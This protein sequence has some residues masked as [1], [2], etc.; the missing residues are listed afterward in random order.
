[1]QKSTVIKKADVKK[2][3]YLIDATGVSLG[4][5]SVA[6]SKL[7]IGKN[8]LTYASNLDSGDNVIVINAKGIRVSD[9]K[10]SLKTKTGKI[11]RKHSGFQGGLKSVPFAVMFSKKPKTVI[12]LAVQGMVPK[13]KMGDQMMSHLFIYEDD[14]Y[15]Q[16]AQKPIK[17]SV[18]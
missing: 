13:T 12:K 10:L 3:W 18:E 6:I 14:K 11:Y 9:K 5:L 15:E 8:K 7:L 17:L 16:E 1:M 2:D 4:K